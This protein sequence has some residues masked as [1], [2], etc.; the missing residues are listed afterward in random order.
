MP[1][2]ACRDKPK[3]SFGEVTPKFGRSLSAQRRRTESGRFEQPAR[4]VALKERDERSR[5]RFT[6]AANH[7]RGINDA[8]RVLER[9]DVHDANTGLP[10]RIGRV[11]DAG[12]RSA[13]P[14]RGQRRRAT[15]ERHHFRRH[16]GPQLHVLD[17]RPGR[18]GDD[19]QLIAENVDAAGWHEP[20]RP[21][22]DIHLRGV[23]ADED[24]DARALHDLPRKCVRASEV[25]PNIDA[26]LIVKR[27]G[28]V[29]RKRAQARRCGNQQ[30]APDDALRAHRGHR[31][32]GQ[33]NEEQAIRGRRKRTHGWNQLEV[34][35]RF[36]IV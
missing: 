20:A 34:L 24:I 35:E 22:Y 2:F 5:I 3:A 26:R 21:L 10:F 14:D 9:Y 13:L 7:G 33:N 28:K 12:F 29:R 15:R 31:C 16:G 6:A 4:H 25:E 32:H 19:D 27:P 18:C 30:I 23:G 11:N 36:N 17:R 8:R 1:A